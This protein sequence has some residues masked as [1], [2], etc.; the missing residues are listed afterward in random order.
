MT[1]PPPPSSKLTLSSLKSS[2]DSQWSKDTMYWLLVQ[3]ASFTSAAN[4]QAMPASTTKH[5]VMDDNDSSE[6]SDTEDESGDDDG[7]QRA[8]EDALDQH[9]CIFNAMEAIFPDATHGI[10]AYHLAQNLKRFCKRRDDLIW[11]YYH[12]MYAY[13]IKEFDSVMG[14]LKE[15]YIALAAGVE[16]FSPVHSLERGV[17]INALASDLYTTRFLKHAYEMGVNPVQDPKFWDI[18]DAIWNRFVLPW[19][20]KNLPRRPKKLRIPSA[21][22]KRKLQ[23]CSKCVW[24]KRTQ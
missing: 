17:S 23:S 8:T 2:I 4:D 19:K 15:N 18:S 6:S 14:E 10:C 7:G 22:E 21:G 1:V 24:K 9:N 3:C 13:R 5:L 12:A 16:N 11:L 20:K